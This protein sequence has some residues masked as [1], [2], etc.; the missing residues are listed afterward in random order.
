MAGTF[1]QRLS[2]LG[3]FVAFSFIR[4]SVLAGMALDHLFFPSIRRYA[5]SSPVVVLGNPRSGTTFLQRFLCDHGVG[6]GM[7][8]W[9][10]LFP[11]PTIAALL[12]PVKGLIDRLSPVRHHME[13]P[14]PTSLDS[15]E[16]EDGA[17]FLRFFDGLLHYC[18]FLAWDEADR[19]ADMDPKAR[20]KHDRD[21]RWL[22]AIWGRCLAA[23]GGRR[24]VSKFFSLSA[25][26]PGFL[27]RFPEARV[28]FCVRDP[29]LTIPSTLSLVTG[30]LDRRFGF[31][32]L[33]KEKRDRY[34]R[35][36]CAALRAL[37]ER[38]VDD[39]QTGRVERRNLMVV[40]YSRLM[41]DFEGMTNEIMNFIGEPV[42]SNLAEEIRLTSEAQK[43]Y[44]SGHRYDLERFGLTE[45]QV[46]ADYEFFYRAF[47][48]EFKKE[49]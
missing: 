25:D 39:L 29:L 7:T 19:L 4:L 34:I 49:A 24:I 16:T 10:M 28:L 31:W 13:G 42:D 21:A 46:R 26:L 22:R 5:I 11:S 44:K 45:A 33:P 6:S 43:S 1:G 18:Y 27:L 37:S 9:R 2:P 41:S 32:S 40:P 3:T 48:E 38:M 47:P 35:R 17:L 30:V 20:G 14:H 15:V 8:V 36:I 23:T 12:R